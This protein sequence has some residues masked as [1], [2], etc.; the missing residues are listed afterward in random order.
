MTLAN[1]ENTNETGWTV[2]S[3]YDVVEYPIYYL[4]LFNEDQSEWMTCQYFN[5]SLETKSKN[6]VD[7]YLASITTAPGYS[8]VQSYL[9]T[10]L[11]SPIYQEVE[12][13]FELSESNVELTQYSAIQS[14]FTALPDDVISYLSS[15]A[16]A[17]NPIWSSDGFTDPANILGVLSGAAITN[18]ASF[19]GVTA[20]PTLT[21]TTTSQTTTTTPAATAPASPISPTLTPSQ[22]LSS[23]AKAGIGVGVAIG[24]LLLAAAAWFIWR[25][26]R[27]QASKEHSTPAVEKPLSEDNHIAIAARPL[28][29]VELSDEPRQPTELSERNSQPAELSSSHS[30]S[31]HELNG[32]MSPVEMRS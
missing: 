21:S 9:S 16:E 12:E 25:W 11:S 27:R 28:R 6:D 17:E 13:L 2:Q 31:R 8:F 29:P 20:F 18:S 24:I 19:T 15:V 32:I 7:A 3:D 10:A 4:V 22:G 14:A 23:G 26:R 30:V 1:S 5:I